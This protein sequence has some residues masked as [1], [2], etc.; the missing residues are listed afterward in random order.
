MVNKMN[1][2][3]PTYNFETERY[4]TYLVGFGDN[5][6]VSHNA[7]RTYKLGKKEEEV[8]YSRQTSVTEN[9]YTALLSMDKIY[10]LSELP[11]K[12]LKDIFDLSDEYDF[13]ITIGNN[14]AIYLNFVPDESVSL[15]TAE[16]VVTCNESIIIVDSAG[17]A[18]ATITVTVVK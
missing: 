10:E 14:E 2:R 6:V 1:K 5:I 8:S 13:F 3:V 18:Y 15:E 12:D 11:Y 9:D 4:H 16:V 17:Y 7:E